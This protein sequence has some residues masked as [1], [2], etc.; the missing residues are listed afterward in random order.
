MELFIATI[1]TVA[2][3]VFAY[4]T[5]RLALNTAKDHSNDNHNTIYAVS[6]KVNGTYCLYNARTDAFLVQ[7]KT[8]QEIQDY[9]DSFRERTHLIITGE[10][11]VNQ[12]INS[13]I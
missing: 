13:S 12:D 2:A 8:V 7:V 6:E 9:I 5:Y 11:P 4:S 10:I 1:F 3:A